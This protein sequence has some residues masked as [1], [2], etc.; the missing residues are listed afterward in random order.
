[1]AHLVGI[2]PRGLSPGRKL[3]EE[4]GDGHV[5]LYKHHITDMLER[6]SKLEEG[7]K[8]GQP[9]VCSH[10]Y[11]GRACKWTACKPLSIPLAGLS[12]IE[13]DEKFAEASRA[14]VKTEDPKEDLLRSAGT[15]S[16]GRHASKAAAIKVAQVTL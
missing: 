8:L 16:T 13:I 15:S 7:P 1:L 5:Q 6:L 2:L 9:V 11:C 4:F 3:A 10:R 12:K 14:S